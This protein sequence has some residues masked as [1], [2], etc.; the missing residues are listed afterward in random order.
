MNLC[1]LF[2]LFFLDSWV[3]DGL[4]KLVS[5]IID[6]QHELTVSWHLLKA[7]VCPATVGDVGITFSE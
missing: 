2:F 4:I 6:I 3:R 5:L 1:F 7:S